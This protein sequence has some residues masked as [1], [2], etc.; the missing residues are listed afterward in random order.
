LAE[1]ADYAPRVADDS[2]RSAAGPGP[3]LP[4]L[5]DRAGALV[6]RP[7]CFYPLLAVS[8]VV[9]FGLYYQR[10]PGTAAFSVPVAYSDGGD[11]FLVL[12]IAQGFSEVP[13]PWNLHV[14]Q[15][16]APFGADWNDYPHT[17][18]LIF[19]PWGLLLRWFDP[20]AVA[21][22]IMLLAHLTAALG[23]ACAA[24]RFGRSPLPSFVGAVLFGF[25]HF[26]LARSLGH[27]NVSFVWHLPLL[28]YL[29][30]RL[31]SIEHPPP[32]K[33]QICAALLLVATSFQNPYYPPLAFQ[34][35]ALATLRSLALGRRSVA[36]FGGLLLAI[37]VGSFLLGQLNVFLRSSSAGSND[38]FSGRSLEAIQTW[39]LRLPDLFMPVGHPITAW[40]DFARTHYFHAGNP[41]SENAAA[42][43]GLVGCCLLVGLVVHSALLGF[44]GRFA[45][46]RGEAWLL[47]YI[48]L[49]SLSG[50]IDY[51]LG[52]LGMTWLRAV[53]RYSI[54]IL[55]LVLFFGCSLLERLRSRLVR[56]ALAALSLAIGLGEAF[57]VG[58]ADYEKHLAAVSRAVNSDRAF[59]RKLERELPKKARV[60]ELPVVEFPE[61]PT[62][63]DMPDCAHF[64]PYLWSRSLRFS[65]GTHKGRPREVWQMHAQQLSPGSMIDYLEAHGFD[66]ILLNRK[67]LPA[68]GRSLEASLERHHL[69]KIAE[70][71]TDDLVAYRLERRASKKPTDFVSVGMD[72]GFPW[73]WEERGSDA[74]AWSDGNA[75]LR[76]I[77]SPGTKKRY[78]IT[79]EAE[80]LVERELAGVVN[81]KTVFA[82]LLLPGKVTPVSF[83]WSP[84][85]PITNIELRTNVPAM[86]PQNGDERVLGFRI[87]NPRAEP[88]SRQSKR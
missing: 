8:M 4:S 25:S 65:Y 5:M 42:F 28:V 47:A 87:A 22:V 77:V 12:G 30:L 35:V 41:L 73:G 68:S 84:V 43:L 21:N 10:F 62:I 7:E 23:F 45:E 67:G 20:G 70:A 58:P 37:A 33:V 86:K 56:T 79:F 39:A 53:N 15:L 71:D 61:S 69:V 9:L 51:L 26:I 36:K 78:R 13:P 16:N 44:R 80:G 49:F 57:G 2:D 31:A 66:A 54:V 50:G 27:V 6:G 88:V 1:A 46:V 55:A 11:V 32:L 75:V 19:Y 40:S 81:G 60:F 18:K 83:D 64:R 29:T 85:E 17:E 74:W 63:R 52:S 82:V 38:R 3:K 48:L 76:L 72:A 14:D 59:T 34:L 24:R